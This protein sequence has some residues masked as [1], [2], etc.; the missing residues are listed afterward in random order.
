MVYF[1]D[2]I[3]I[4][5]NSMEKI[6]LIINLLMMFLL[7]LLLKLKQLLKLLMELVKAVYM[8]LIIVVQWKILMWFHPDNKII[9]LGLFPEINYL[10]MFFQ[11]NPLIKLDKSKISRALQSNDNFADN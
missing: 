2:N 11:V 5:T 1:T 8:N 10:E 9:E 4:L 6:A 3:P 7:S